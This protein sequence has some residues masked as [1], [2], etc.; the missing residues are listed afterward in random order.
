MSIITTIHPIYRMTS[1]TL[2]LRTCSFSGQP[3]R[4]IR[5][6]PVHVGD[7]LRRSRHRV[8]WR[9][10]DEARAAGRPVPVI[11]RELM[12]G[13]LC[14]RRVAFD[15]GLE[16]HRYVEGPAGHLAAAGGDDPGELA[17]RRA[18]GAFVRMRE[19]LADRPVRR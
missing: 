11:V 4:N 1:D 12:E 15:A 13:A 2:V 6:V 3:E 5:R 8:A 18:D 17:L 19:E 10:V 7:C 9:L 14:D 16:R